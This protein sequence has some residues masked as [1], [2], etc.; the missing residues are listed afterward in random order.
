VTTVWFGACR[1]TSVRSRR[2]WVSCGLQ[3]ARL[4]RPHMLRQCL[5]RLI[6]EA[7]GRSVISWQRRKSGEAA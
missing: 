2:A 6:R 5:A 3:G 4:R 1:L 7:L